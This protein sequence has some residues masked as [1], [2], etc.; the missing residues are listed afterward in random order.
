MTVQANEPKMA[1]MFAP[2]CHSCRSRQ[3]LGFPRIVASAWESGGPIHLRCRC[4]A[5]V[6]ADARPPDDVE[7][8]HAS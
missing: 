6:A 5:I 2:Y 7:L 8:R 4:G 1:C 3:L